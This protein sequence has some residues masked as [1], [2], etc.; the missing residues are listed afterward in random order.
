MSGQPDIPPRKNAKRGLF[1]PPGSAAK[2]QKRVR[3][4]HE[5]AEPRE[6]DHENEPGIDIVSEKAMSGINSCGIHETVMHRVNEALAA[7][8]GNEGTDIT[9]RLIPVITTAVTVAV[10][11][12]MKEA[13]RVMVTE[14]TKSAVASVSDQFAAFCA[15]KGPSANEKHLMSVVT[16][17]TYDNDR[18][19]QYSRRESLRIY[20]LKTEDE[21]TAEAVE[22]KALKVFADAGVN[23]AP[24]DIAAVHRAGKGTKGTKPILVKFVSRKKRRGIQDNASAGNGKDG[25]LNGNKG[26]DGGME[27]EDKNYHAKGGNVI[28]VEITDEHA[29]KEGMYDEHVR[30]LHEKAEI[31]NSVGILGSVDHAMNGYGDVTVIDN[32]TNEDDHK[33]IDDHVRNGAVLTVDHITNE[34]KVDQSLTDTDNCVINEYGDHAMSSDD[35]GYS[36]TDGHGMGEHVVSVLTDGDHAL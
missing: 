34:D 14:V 32:G 35:V 21:E 16:R 10:T 24:E 19:Q 3:T 25:E 8:S 12:A 18:L 29:M 23:I 28:D 2:E 11:E 30:N 4:A 13:V 27:T 36:F 22:K 20:G 5:G 6:M 17:L 31:L 7:F 9:Q 15:T 33:L 26:G 1:S